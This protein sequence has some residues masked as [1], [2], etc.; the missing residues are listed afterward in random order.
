MFGGALAILL[1]IK[2]HSAV[3]FDNTR[4]RFFVGDKIVPIVELRK[5]LDLLET[6]LAK[7]MDLYAAR[8][9]SGQWTIDKWRE[10]MEALIKESH[11]LFGALAM[12]SV[13]LAAVSG[14]VLARTDRDLYYLGKFAGDIKAKK[15]KSPLMLK[16]RAKSYIRSMRITYAEIE[17]KLHIAAGFKEAKR[18]L[19]A[20]ESCPRCLYYRGRWIKIELMPPI[21]SLSGSDGCGQYCKCYLIYR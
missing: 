11:S 12:G 5:Q 19:R 7:T 10:E 6:K 15:V 1:A 14:T 16:R 18:I 21:G 20:N 9:Q 13:A 2:A 17:L 4:L 8:L 3:R